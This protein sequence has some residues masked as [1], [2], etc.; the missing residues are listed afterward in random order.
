MIKRTYISERNGSPHTYDFYLARR[1]DPKWRADFLR[2]QEKRKKELR[3][4][5]TTLL[6][7]LIIF[8]ISFFFISSSTALY[9]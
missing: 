4:Y 2:V 9:D 8:G 3:I 1:N 7:V 5:Y 6:L